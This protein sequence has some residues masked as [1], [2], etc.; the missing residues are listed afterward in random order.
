MLY[1]G[2]TSEP[3]AVVDAME[4]ENV[5]RAERDGRIAKIVAASA[6]TYSALAKSMMA[7]TASLRFSASVRA[8]DLGGANVRSPSAS[9]WTRTLGGRP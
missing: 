1:L 8:D 4:M 3:L 7:A 6:R 2:N 5:L 9:Q